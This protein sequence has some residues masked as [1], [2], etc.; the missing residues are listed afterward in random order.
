A[1]IMSRLYGGAALILGVDGAGKAEDELDLDRVR[2]GSLKFVHAV[3]C[4]DISVPELNRDLMTP[5]YGT[6]AYYE[7][8]TR[9]LGPVKIHPT[10]VI[11]L[12]GNELM[13]END[14]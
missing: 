11:R 4:H 12:V 6:P 3:A 13:D 10:R 9:D 2:E 7:R 8:Q 5:L 1:Q 14:L